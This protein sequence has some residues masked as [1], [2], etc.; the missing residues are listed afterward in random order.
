ML[1]FSLKRMWENKEIT[2]VMIS[3][4]PKITRESVNKLKK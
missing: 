3:G 2:M 1:R 4:K